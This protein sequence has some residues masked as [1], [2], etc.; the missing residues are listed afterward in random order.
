MRVRSRLGNVREDGGKIGLVPVMLQGSAL[1]KKLLIVSSIEDDLALLIQEVLRALGGKASPTLIEDVLGL[2]VARVTYHRGTEL[3][4]VGLIQRGIVGRSL[5]PPRHGLEVS[6]LHA[7][8]ELAANLGVLAVAELL[9]GSL[10]T[11][12]V[13]DD[14]EIKDI[15]PSRLILEC[16][17]VVSC[18]KF[19][20]Q[21][22][23]SKYKANIPTTTPT[24]EPSFK[25]FLRDWTSVRFSFW[26]VFRVT[27][28]PLPS[29]MAASANSNSADPSSAELLSAR[30]F[31][32]TR[33]PPLLLQ[34]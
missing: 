30:F 28:D 21:R 14:E 24:Y 7:D 3:V 25:P 33:P 5:V 32:W 2:N 18:S 8:T 11:P 31:S 29:A 4:A 20:R 16:M 1:G 27:M 19:Q 10:L 22:Q 15:V 34:G 13:G 23:S 6:L 9:E 26:C 12:D 17:K